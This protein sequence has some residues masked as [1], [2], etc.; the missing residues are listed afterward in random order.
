M[1]PGVGSRVTASSRGAGRSRPDP[2]ASF[3]AEADGAGT[4]AQFNEIA[5]V[6]D[7]TRPPVDPA[8][9]ARLAEWFRGV[10][11]RRLLEV[12]VGTG[13]VAAPLTRLG[14]SVTGLDAARAMLVRARDKGVAVPVLGD[15]CLL[16]FRDGAFDGVLMARLLHT[17]DRPEVAL[18]E[19]RRVGRRGAFALITDRTPVGRRVPSPAG[20]ELRKLLREELAREGITLP[21][22]HAGGPWRKER[23]ALRRTPPTD[24]TPL[25]ERVIEVPADRR[26]IWAERGADRSTVDLP[27]EA[28]QRA[29]ARVR[30]RLPPERRAA[31]VLFRRSY[32]L[33]RWSPGG[34]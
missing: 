16:P 23:L 1:T 3:S 31:R 15:A 17:L 11:V 24:V 12:G 29:V 26:L 7:Q 32:A 28:V 18:A 10:G 21:P 2:P 6:Y 20:D 19:A 8:T 33:A 9:L 25:G 30:E 34:A 27:R 14:L 13:R 5:P 22:S 4:I